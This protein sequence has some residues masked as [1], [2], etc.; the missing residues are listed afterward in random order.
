[1]AAK[2]LGDEFDIHG[3]GIDL[4]FPHHE[5]ELAQSS[6]AGKPFARWWMHNAWITA[7][8]LQAILAPRG[9]RRNVPDRV[10]VRAVVGHGHLAMATP[11]PA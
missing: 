8:D 2:Y 1:M 6:A 9:R 3:G 4:R 7:A 5:N 11:S 10:E